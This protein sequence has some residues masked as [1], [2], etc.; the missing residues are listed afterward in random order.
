MKW[1]VW[2]SFFGRSSSWRVIR[3]DPRGLCFKA[4]K[5]LPPGAHEVRVGLHV[6][7]A[8]GK[9]PQTLGRLMV[10]H[11]IHQVP[12]LCAPGFLVKVIRVRDPSPLGNSNFCEQFSHIWF[13]TRPHK[14][15]VSNCEFVD[16]HPKCPKITGMIVPSVVNEF[17]CQVLRGPTHCVGLELNLLLAIYC[18]AERDLLCKPQINDPRV[19]FHINHEIF[20]FQIPVSNSFLMHMANCFDHNSTIE[21]CMVYWE[22]VG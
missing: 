2:V 14:W 17:W 3:R 5:L 19:T 18:C 12:T 16:E 11:F 9:V 20:W 15:S 21:F 13:S 1:D 10:H 6:G 22:T 4:N 7:H 8:A